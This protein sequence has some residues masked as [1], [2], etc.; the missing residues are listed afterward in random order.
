MADPN[1]QPGHPFLIPP[2]EWLAFAGAMLI[3]LS[4]GLWSGAAIY[5]AADDALEGGPVP[6]YFAAFS[7]ATE[8]VPALLG[9]QLLYLLAVMVGTVFC[10]LP[11]IWLG[12]LLV[13]AMPR[14]A[15]RDVGPMTALQDARALVTGR[16]WRVAGFCL[17][18]G[19]TIYAVYSPYFFLNMILP[20][21][22]RVALIV[23]ATANI[24]AAALIAPFQLCAY[25]ALHRRL[26][27]TA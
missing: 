27:E 10:I 25:A 9:T 11:G 16:W 5:R 17:L 8:R 22:D 20:H 12:I 7:R 13:P 14:A 4:F 1:P 6:G 23:R 21:G 2:S 19:I 15:T 3:A 24:G 26:E 18:V